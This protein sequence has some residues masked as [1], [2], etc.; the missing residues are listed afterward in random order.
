LIAGKD[1]CTMNF[2]KY[3]WDQFLVTVTELLI[4]LPVGVPVKPV[5]IPVLLV[6]YSK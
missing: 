4:N 2:I 6:H 5:G 3:Y 1:A